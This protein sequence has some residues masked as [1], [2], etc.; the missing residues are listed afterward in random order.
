MPLPAELFGA[1]RLVSFEDRETEADEWADSLG[2]D[3]RG[4]MIV[5][6]PALVSVQIQAEGPL[7]V[8]YFGTASVTDVRGDDGHLTGTLVL[9]LEGGHPPEALGGDEPRPFSLAGDELVLGD[10]RTWRR[11]LARVAV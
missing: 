9:E 6:P 7:Y 11:R 8:G 4:L 3:P 1:W 2:P 5:H 10:Q